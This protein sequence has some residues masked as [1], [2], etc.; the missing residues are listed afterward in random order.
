M[1]TRTWNLWIDFNVILIGIA[2]KVRSYISIKILEWLRSSLVRY[3]RIPGF[4]VLLYLLAAGIYLSVHLVYPRP[5]V[6]DLVL[7][8]L[9]FA[10]LF[11]S[12]LQLVAKTKMNMIYIGMRIVS[13]P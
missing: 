7:S 12:G 9:M 2:I 4:F 6:F 11:Q 3:W 10:G 13:N 5:L 1:Q 8:P